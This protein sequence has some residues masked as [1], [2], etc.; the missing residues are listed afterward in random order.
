MKNKML[1]R[2]QIT[3]ILVL[4]FLAVDNDRYDEQVF[5]FKLKKIGKKTI[6]IFSI[7]WCKNYSSLRIIATV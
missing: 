4:C 2:R 7:R 6:S 5:P 3:F 1:A